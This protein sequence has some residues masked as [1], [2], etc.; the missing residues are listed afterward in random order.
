MLNV[1]AMAI[2]HCII[3]SATEMAGHMGFRDHYACTLKAKLPT[4]V[5]LLFNQ[6]PKLGFNIF[7]GI[8]WEENMVEKLLHAHVEHLP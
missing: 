6:C 1:Q 8:L 4:I 3:K 7:Q 5:N 2:W